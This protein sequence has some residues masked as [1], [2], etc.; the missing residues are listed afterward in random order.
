MRLSAS[1]SDRFNPQGPSD[2]GG[3]VVRF[4]TYG[5]VV[6]ATLACLLGAGWYIA[7]GE[8]P[9]DIWRQTAA[10]PKIDAPMPPRLGPEKPATSL[11]R[12]PN[13]ADVKMDMAPVDKHPEKAAEKPTEPAKPAPAET[14]KTNE[15]PPAPALTEPVIPPGGEP[16]AAPSFAQ[17]PA[18]TDLKP[19]GPAPLAELL[20]TTSHGTL[21]VMAG[22]KESRTAYARPFTGDKT[23][24]KIA[25]VV[26]GLGLSKDATEAAITKLPPDISLSFSP[27][28]DGLENWIKKARAA[29]H[30]VLLDLPLEPPNFPIRDAGPMAVLSQNSPAEAQSRVEQVLTRAQGYV[31]VAAALRS[32]VAASP[33]WGPMLRGLKGRG[34]LMVG[35]GLAGVAE[36]D[37]PASASVTLVADETPFRAAIDARLSRLMNTAQKEG[38]ALTYVS[39]RPVTFERLLAWIG[40][41][42]QRG[43][44]LA[45]ASTVAHP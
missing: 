21:P 40:S 35:D 1:A 45:P 20:K 27:Y 10:V 31:G 2:R 9:M 33:Q 25:I 13:P 29:G 36:T 4:L 16:L 11:M 42:P 30:E 22:G 3:A 6:P 8:T 26:V 5:L 15:P 14:A 19:L 7:T 41:F 32:P 12:P 44:V 39:P 43:V 18:R 23:Q 28:A 37:L 38:T 34:L 17:L 24:P